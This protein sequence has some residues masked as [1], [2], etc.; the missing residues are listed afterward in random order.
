VRDRLPGV[1][2]PDDRR[3]VAE[4]S[5]ATDIDLSTVVFADESDERP[6]ETVRRQ[7]SNVAVW[8]LYLDTPCGC[9]GSTEQAVCDPCHQKGGGPPDEN[10]VYWCADCGRCNGSLHV[11]RLPR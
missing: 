1:P 2:G 8:L 7:C 6:C 10:I 11:R 5:T 9:P 3:K 4:V